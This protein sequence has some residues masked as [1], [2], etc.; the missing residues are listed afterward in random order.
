MNLVGLMLPGDCLLYWH[1]SPLAYAI[2]AVTKHKVS[3]VAMYAGDWQTHEATLKGVNVYPVNTEHLIAIRRPIYNFD[4][5][6]AR[7]W[8]MI[9]ARYQ[10][11]DWLADLGF[12]TGGDGAKGKMMCAEC[13]AREYRHGD[14]EPFEGT[15]RDADKVAPFEFLES[16]FFKDVWLSPTIKIEV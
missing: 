16:K 10:S 7:D 2:W 13:C 6:K 4:F 15:R 9:H 8:F 11:Y 1:P 5:N 3:H 14:F 12:I